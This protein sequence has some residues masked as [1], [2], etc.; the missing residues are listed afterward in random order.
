[1][2][3]PLVLFVGFRM[4]LESVGDVMTGYSMLTRLS[5]SIIEKIDLLKL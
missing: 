2:K 3:C 1:M 5:D 4:N